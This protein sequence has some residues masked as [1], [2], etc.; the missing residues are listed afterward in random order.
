MPTPVLTYFHDSLLFLTK[1][2]LHVVRIMRRRSE[3]RASY[4]ASRGNG[5]CSSACVFCLCPTEVPF[6]SRFAF[7]NLWQRLQAKAMGHATTSSVTPRKYKA[8]NVPSTLSQT[9]DWWQSLPVESQFE[10]MITEV[11]CRF[12]HFVET[13]RAGSLEHFQPSKIGMSSLQ[14]NLDGGDSDV[15]HDD[16][17][18]AVDTYHRNMEDITACTQQ[19]KQ[20]QQFLWRRVPSF[21]DDHFND[22]ERNCPRLMTISGVRILIVRWAT[23][24]K[25]SFEIAAAHVASLFGMQRVS[26]SDIPRLKHH[27]IHSNTRPH[28]PR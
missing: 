25:E 14:T 7:P 2:H 17:H 15:G 1:G 9:D 11:E 4:A 28:S 10:A 13:L 18:E 21:E 8:S 24:E 27:R 19:L 26:V 16:L 3:V 5:P 6:C 12:Q 23:K 22:N 20:H